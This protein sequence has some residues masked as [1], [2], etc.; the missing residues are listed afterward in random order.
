[1]D[2]KRVFLAIFLSFLVLT[3]YQIYFISSPPSPA[4]VTQSPATSGGQ[5]QTTPSTAQP[6]VPLTTPPPVVAPGAAP[7]ISDAA[8]R[9]ILVET[10]S[11][12]AVFSTHGASLKSWRL[13]HY[14][15]DKPQKPA[16][17]Y[18]QKPLELVPTDLPAQYARPFTLATDDAAVSATL[19]SALYRPSVDRLTLGAGTGELTFEFSDAS[20]LVAHKHFRFQPNNT[21]YVVVVD[22]TV[23]V[24]GAALPV[25]FDL[26]PSVAAGYSG[27]GSRY[28]YPPA[29]SQERDGKV[30]R[31][32][33]SN[34][35][36]LSEYTGMMGFAGVGDQY[37]LSAVI[38]VFLAPPG[39]PAARKLTLNYTPISLPIPGEEAPDKKRTFVA[40]RVRA[41]APSPLAFYLGP[42]NFDHLRAIDTRLLQAI[43]FGMFRVLVVPLLQSLK[44]INGYIGNFGWSIIVLTLIINLA[45][46]PLRHRSMISM[47]KMQAL[48]PQ[49]KAIQD[50]YAKYKMTDP[51]RGKMQ[52]ELA[53]LYKEKGV[54]PAGGCLPML[55]TMPVLFA[56]YQMLAVAIELRAA[57]FAFWITD[58]A[59]Y[60]RFYI[61]PLLMG[62][63]MFWQQ[64]LMPS[65]ADPMQKKIFMIMP[66]AF[67]F[68]FLWAPSGLVLYWLMSNLM[69]IGQQYVTNR[70]IGP[71]P[72]TLPSIKRKTT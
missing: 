56:F 1:M 66:I 15:E 53:A 42:K 6:A 24:K 32:S 13:K 52:Q 38:P 25:I 58:L 35:Q 29:V 21:P 60:D 20:G 26:G 55:L 37:F 5:V 70:I 44:W 8:A 30:E 64:W 33:D 34:L 57:P 18:Q 19:A 50:R 67:T 11:V 71:P 4:P 68:G 3:V 45:M 36:Q 17:D 43:D 65:T 39:A 23:D 69:A 22:A 40:Y 2:Q 16:A 51:E 72:R 61:T 54:S 12:S 62:G 49:M 59:H 10:D 14:L 48:Q 27:Q 31:F 9:D 46:F 47:R 7:I 28:A 63:T 41:A